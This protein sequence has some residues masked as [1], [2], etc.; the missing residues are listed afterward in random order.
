[1]NRRYQLEQTL[2]QNLI[3]NN[4][5]NVE[6]IIC[7]FN[8][9]DNLKNYIYSNFRK[10]LDSGYL[11]Y[12]FF[13][14]I[15]YWHASICKNT[16]HLKANGKYIVNLD[17]DNFIGTN[18]SELLLDTYNKYGD[19]IIIHQNDNIYGSG[20]AGRISML[21]N[22]FIKLGGYDEM[23][24][25]MGYQDIDIIKRGERMG[26]KVI[27]INKN[28]KCIKNSK[29]ESCK[30]IGTNI[31]YIKMNNINILISKVNL[32]NNNII[33]NKYKKIGLI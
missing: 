25:P 17:C 32:E 16:T 19:N 33:A 24:Y 26:L 22:N 13:N 31:D 8:S 14:N 27:N 10:E 1:M 11:K 30:N 15:N 5:D 20:N 2:Q 4:L 29:L 21:K 3:D 28:N 7:D 23:F 18:G 12:F 9:T 6:F